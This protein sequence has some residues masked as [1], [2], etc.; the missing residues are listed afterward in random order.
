MPGP[1]IFFSLI[2]IILGWVV[3]CEDWF[4][5][6]KSTSYW[7]FTA[8]MRRNRAFC[9]SILWGTTRNTP[10]TQKQP[11]R[12]ESVCTC[13]YIYQTENKGNTGS[14]LFQLHCKSKWPMLSSYTHFSTCDQT[15]IMTL[16]NTGEDSYRNH[17]R[18][19]K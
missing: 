15:Y 4:I 6:I 8:Q 13:A 17:P 7:K 3:L 1:I 14:H 18:K 5:F 2:I 19:R 12:A 16:Y 10:V 11:G 9:K